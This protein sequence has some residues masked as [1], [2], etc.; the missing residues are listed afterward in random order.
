[1]LASPGGLW[2]TV[3]VHARVCA[4]MYMYVCVHVRACTCLCMH[5]HMHACTCLCACH[6]CVRAYVYVCK[7]ACVHTCVRA[8]VCVCTCACVHVSVCMHMSVCACMHV[9]TS[10]CVCVRARVCVCVYMCAH[11]FLCVH[12]CTCLCVH[13][14][15]LAF[16][17]SP[18][19]STVYMLPAAWALG[20]VHSPPHSPSKPE[21]TGSLGPDH[22]DSQGVLGQPMALCPDSA[23]HGPSPCLS[24]S[25]SLS[26]LYLAT[27]TPASQWSFSRSQV[28]LTLAHSCWAFCK[29][30]PSAPSSVS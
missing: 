20:K 28:T 26:P 6:V 22:W 15:V 27:P 21:P 3:S 7:C 18:A 1:M 11:T 17:L 16:G 13:V 19:S 23:E 8:H 30:G 24:P 9:H 2:A 4:C 10:V 29:Q 14:C 5:V 12:V 25:V